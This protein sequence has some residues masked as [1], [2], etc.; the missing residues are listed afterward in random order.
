MAGTDAIL[1]LLYRLL[2]LN[3]ILQTHWC[4]GKSCIAVC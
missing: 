3:I 4:R 2:V 1:P